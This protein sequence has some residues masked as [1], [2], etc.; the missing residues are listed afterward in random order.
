MKNVPKR[1]SENAVLLCEKYVSQR[2][3]I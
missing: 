3:K 1:D 2:I